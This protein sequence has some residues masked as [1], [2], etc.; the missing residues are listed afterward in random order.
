MQNFFKSNV[1]VA[2]LIRICLYY[3][4]YVASLMWQVLTWLKDVAEPLWLPE[5]ALRYL[6]NILAPAKLVMVSWA[7][8]SSS[9]SSSWKDAFGFKLRFSGLVFNLVA[10]DM[11]DIVTL[12]ALEPDMNENEL[13][14]DYRRI[15]R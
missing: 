6:C 3:E 8:P 12:E 9:S 10:L 7:P 13:V 11:D 5:M 15:D 14:T 4:L 2:I 1:S